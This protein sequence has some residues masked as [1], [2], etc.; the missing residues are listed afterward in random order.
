MFVFV[1]NTHTSTSTN[2]NKTNK[3]TNNIQFITTLRNKFDQNPRQDQTTKTNKQNTLI[4]QTHKQ[5][6][7]KH[8]PTYKNRHTTQHKTKTHKTHHKHNTA[9]QNKHQY[10]THTTTTH[11]KHTN[12]NHNNNKQ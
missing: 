2:N 5:H 8:F 9:I 4:K 7:T 12:N 11:K 3:Y 10:T 6:T 1:K